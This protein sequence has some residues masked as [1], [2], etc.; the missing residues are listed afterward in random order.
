[1]P[2]SDM[3]IRKERSSDYLE[4]ASPLKLKMAQ[5][6]FLSL[7]NQFVICIVSLN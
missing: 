5:G 1:M 3:K 6:L 4:E 2:V 7:V